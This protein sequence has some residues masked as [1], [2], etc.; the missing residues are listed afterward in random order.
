MVTTTEEKIIANIV[1]AEVYL[2]STTVIE[3]RSIITLESNLEQGIII[4]EGAQGPAGINEEDNVYAKRIDF[5]GDNIIYKAEAIVGSVTSS[6]VWR[7]RKITLAS[8]NDVTEVWADGDAQ[9]NN[10]WDNHL[11]LSYT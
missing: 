4:G 10:I 1:A 8:D 3:D 5:V 9:F 2:S 6:P 11:S 7:I